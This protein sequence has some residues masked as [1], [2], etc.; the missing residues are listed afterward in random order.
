[1]TKLPDWNRDWS[2]IAQPEPEGLGPGEVQQSPPLRRLEELRIVFNE[3]FRISEVVQ[4]SSLHAPLKSASMQGPPKSSTMSL[5]D[6]FPDDSSPR[7]AQMLQ[8]MNWDPWRTPGAR[9]GMRTSGAA[10]PPDPVHTWRRASPSQA[11]GPSAVSPKL[12]F[13]WLGQ[14]SPYILQDTKR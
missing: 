1:M 13:T 4:S 3:I 2:K 8:S 7:S 10:G 5:S 12:P 14:G 11:S 9:R 6:S